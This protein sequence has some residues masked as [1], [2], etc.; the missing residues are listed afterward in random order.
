MDNL[1]TRGGESQ[2]RVH[3]ACFEKCVASFSDT[4]L[5]KGEQECVKHCFKNFAFSFKYGHEA[6][7]AHFNTARANPHI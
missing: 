1:E 5:D 6:M 2:L 4:K 3:D 7:K